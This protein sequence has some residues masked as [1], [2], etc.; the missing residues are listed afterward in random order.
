MRLLFLSLGY[1]PCVE[2][3][4]GYMVSAVL[5][6]MRTDYLICPCC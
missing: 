5:P 1:S 2:K 6:L 3:A 4:D